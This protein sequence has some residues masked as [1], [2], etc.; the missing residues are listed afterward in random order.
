MTPEQTEWLDANRQH[1]LNAQIPALEILDS[2]ITVK[3]FSTKKDDYQTIASKDTQNEQIRALLDALKSKCKEAFTEFITA[4]ETHC[5]HALKE[6]Q[7]PPDVIRQFD[8][9]VRTY[10]RTLNEEEMMAFS[11][12]ERT[13]SGIKISDYLRHL[14]VIDKRQNEAMIAEKLTSS[15]KELERQQLLYSRPEKVELVELENIFGEEFQPPRKRRRVAVD[16]SCDRQARV[17]TL[18]SKATSGAAVLGWERSSWSFVETT[19]KPSWRVRSSWLRQN[20]QFDEVSLF[21]RTRPTVA[22]PIPLSPFLEVAR[23]RCCT[24]RNIST[25]AQSIAFQSFS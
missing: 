18:Q 6:C 21:V 13:S 19:T 17:A 1:L 12:L 16:V 14:A 23:S 20:G 11:W 22:T 4:L 9:D 8:A 15:T 7:N 5:L 25:V 2:L 10:Y 24:G 3:V